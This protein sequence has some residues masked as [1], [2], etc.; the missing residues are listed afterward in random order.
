MTLV[1]SKC[2]VV[3]NFA[4]TQGLVLHFLKMLNSLYPSIQYMYSKVLHNVFSTET[5][6]LYLNN[7]IYT[8]LCQPVLRISDILVRIRIRGSVPLT[9]GS[10]FG[11]CYFCQ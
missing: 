7:G 3:F 10:G 2:A 8:H 5:T 9:N 6:A 11:S 4:T 1:F